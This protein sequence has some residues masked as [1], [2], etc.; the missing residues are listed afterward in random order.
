M[1][2]QGTDLQS[3]PY[4]AALVRSA[5]ASLPIGVVV[6][7]ER[8]EEVLRNGTASALTGDYQADAV[9][10]SVIDEVAQAAA[11]DEPRTVDV[12]GPR[13][14]TF[15]L[16]A[17]PLPPGG[18]AVVVEDI[19][20]QQRL[21]R[22]K[23]DFVANVSHELRTPV[24]AIVLLS[25]TLEKETDP[26]SVALLQAHI[27]EESRRAKRLVDALLVLSRVEVMAPPREHL[28]DLAATVRSAVGLVA[29]FAA[30]SGI[31]VEMNL[32]S[33]SPAV[34]GDE[35]ALLSAVTNLVEN[36]VKYSDRGSAVHVEVM[37]EPDASVLSV[38][39]AGIGIPAKDL[40]RIFERFYRVDR[41]RSRSTGGAGLGLAIVKHV[42]ESC[43]GEV[44]VQSREGEGT[45]FT[46]RLPEPSG[47]GDVA[48]PQVPG[49]VR[50]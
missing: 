49:G 25:E 34:T 21:D 46:V 31:T 39:D 9:L 50:P 30:E 20:E 4:V 17:M 48:G 12:H 19:S 41:A 5:L 26:E 47:P 45:T 3:R 11:H 27:T 24:G 33:L 42:V 1:A 13:L 8:G 43:G 14:R 6:Y 35:E 10:E 16:Q 37:L 40:E 44:A 36:A 15:R 38:R 22:V 23:R 7:D 28:V 2:E 32:P 29:P 18:C